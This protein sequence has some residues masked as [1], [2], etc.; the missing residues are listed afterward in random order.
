MNEKHLHDTDFAETGICTGC[1]TR[2]L[3]V[4]Q[5]RALPGML[6]RIAPAVLTAHGAY[7]YK[8]LTTGLVVTLVRKESN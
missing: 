6:G 7:T 8:D 1:H 2:A 4:E 5:A 3:T